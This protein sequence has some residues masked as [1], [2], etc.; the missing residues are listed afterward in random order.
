MIERPANARRP[1]T[2]SAASWPKS[3]RNQPT[4][5]EGGRT[6]EG[7][8]RHLE[9]PYPRE[10]EPSENPVNSIRVRGYPLNRPCIDRGQGVPQ[11]IIHGA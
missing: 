1:L 5:V 8:A 6:D 2:K 4:M 7:L 11:S 10:S 9:G 3:A